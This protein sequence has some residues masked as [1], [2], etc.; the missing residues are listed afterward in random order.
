MPPVEAKDKAG[1][2]RVMSVQSA[3][4]A[5]GGLPRRA[6]LIAW[7]AL[8]GIGLYDWRRSIRTSPFM[9]AV[10][11][12]GAGQVT[13]HLLYGTETFLYSLN[14]VPVLIVI[15][16]CGTRTRARGLVNALAALLLVCG[17][18]S[19]MRTWL[20]SRRYFVVSPPI[21][22]QR[23][24]ERPA[25]REVHLNI[26]TPPGAG[27]SCTAVP[28]SRNDAPHAEP[29]SSTC[30]ATAWAQRYQQ[31]HAPSHNGMRGDTT[32]R[33]KVLLTGESGVGK[34]VFAHYI[35]TA[36]GAGGHR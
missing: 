26:A 17:G 8:F 14:A 4:L 34:E 16:A 13:L 19:N 21:H 35:H 33:S 2:G 3:G 5:A 22:A 32:S 1:R 24:R 6:A 31:R 27:A 25:Q 20:E 23:D 30:R 11:A 28:W 15:A 36:A 7:F 18:I 12:V 29:L 10:A 9:R